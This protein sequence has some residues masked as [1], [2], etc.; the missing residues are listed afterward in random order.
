MRLGT[1]GVRG[2]V[3]RFQARAWTR[4]CRSISAGAQLSL[5]AARACYVPTNNDRSRK[6]GSCVLD[7]TFLVSCITLCDH[8]ITSSVSR[9]RGMK[10]RVYPHP[11]ESSP[12]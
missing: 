4:G 3:R 5:A 8:F 11:L 9:A 10:S 1:H 6:F 2:G 7:H 12:P